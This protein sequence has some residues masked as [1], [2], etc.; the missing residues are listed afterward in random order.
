M[1]WKAIH[2]GFNLFICSADFVPEWFHCFF[3]L[4]YVTK[5]DKGLY[6]RAKPRAEP[7]SA[8]FPEKSPLINDVVVRSVQQVPTITPYPSSLH[9][10]EE[11]MPGKAGMEEVADDKGTSQDNRKGK[12]WNEVKVQ[13]ADLP[14]IYAKLSKIKL[15]GTA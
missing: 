10:D 8:P 3:L 6:Q 15:T 1:F 13:L 7:S 9:E 4:Q 2:C 11:Q 14:G 5:V 12:Q